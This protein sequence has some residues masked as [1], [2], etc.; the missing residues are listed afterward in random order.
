MVTHDLATDSDDSASVFSAASSE[1]AASILA[2]VGMSQFSNLKQD[3]WQVHVH[4][5]QVHVLDNR[6]SFPLI[7]RA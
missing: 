7:V 4:D 1:G 2:S 6:V 5:R 3:R